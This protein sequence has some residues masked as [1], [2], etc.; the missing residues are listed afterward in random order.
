MNIFD[1]VYKSFDD[2]KSKGPGFSSDKWINSSKEKLK[3]L[4]D[5]KEAVLVYQNLLPF[6]SSIVLSRGK[7]RILDF[8]GGLGITYATLLKTLDFKEGVFEYHIVENERIC[9]EGRK[10]FKTDKRIY[11]HNKLPKISSV[12]IVHIGSALQYIK[13]WKELLR[14]LS[15]YK[16]RYFLFDDLHAGDITTFATLQNYY[17]SKIPCWF[18][19]LNELI[20]EMRKHKFD[21]AYKSKMRITYFGVFQKIP[22]KNLPKKYRI[23]D[24]MCLLFRASNFSSNTSS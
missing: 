20:S 23:D 7:I 9:S 17:E 19:N 4:L 24:T 10:I 16:P 21:L 12:D 8:G 5:G 18:F 14:D 11:F 22:M 2:A 6:L 1:G 13:D 3:K 15:A